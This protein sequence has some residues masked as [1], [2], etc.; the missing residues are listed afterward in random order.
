MSKTFMDENYN[1][2]VNFNP[3][4]HNGLP[5]AARCKMTWDF[6]AFGD[7]EKVKN[8]LLTSISLCHEDNC[9]FCE[10]GSETYLSEIEI[11]INLVSDDSDGE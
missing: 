2:A 3:E 8:D 4:A 6:V 10:E 1:F 11:K 9:L 5:Y 7:V